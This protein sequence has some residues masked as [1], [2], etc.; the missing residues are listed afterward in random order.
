MSGESIQ[1]QRMEPI[2]KWQ[3]DQL[4]K[5]LLLLQDH[6]T[7][8]TCPCETAGEMCVRK[9]LL[10]IEAYAQETLAMEHEEPYREK[11]SLLAIE[12]KRHRE[13]EEASLLNQDDPQ[14]L[15]KWTRRWRKEFEEYSLA[16]AAEAEAEAEEEGEAA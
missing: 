7:D 6:Q 11:L 5:E 8:K 3:Y 4:L 13:Q 15:T 10:T 1:E 16:G 12:A 2:L 14:D 9:H